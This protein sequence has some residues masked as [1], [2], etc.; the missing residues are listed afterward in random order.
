MKLSISNIAWDSVFDEEMY[1]FLHKMNFSGLEIA[2]T[3]IFPEN[4]Y[5]KISEAGKFA[6]KLKEKYG[7]AIPS[8]QSIWYGKSQSIFGTDKEKQELVDYT[9][10]AIDFAYEI[11]C[12]NLVFGCP[13]NRNMP[14]GKSE[15]EAVEFFREIGK[16]AAEKEMVIAL[17]A[18]P[19]IYNT[20][21]MNTTQQAVDIC[22]KVNCKGVMVNADLGTVIYND[23]KLSV[24]ADNID[25]IN[26]IHIS[27]PHL[28]VIEK[29]SLHKE[30]KSLRYD[31]FFSIEMGNKNDLE[32]V[33]STVEYIGEVFGL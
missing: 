23:E 3:R 2:P 19:P 12:K 30:L 14:D 10:K 17:E 29:R 8:M 1:A 31:N 22:K 21:F 20:N 27:E 4:P 32:L 6:E 15:D 7:L 28:A 16:Y 13:R 24:I 18:N 33:K 9:K 11:N 25:L 5:D 26:H